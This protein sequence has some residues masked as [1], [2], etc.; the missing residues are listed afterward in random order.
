[1]SFSRVPAR[2]AGLAPVCAVVLGLA[3]LGIGSA[4]GE[5]TGVGF[6]ASIEGRMVVPAQSTQK[7]QD[8]PAE[9]GAPPLPPCA[10]PRKK[11]QLQPRPERDQPS[12]SAPG[13]PEQNLPERFTP[14]GPGAIRPCDQ[15]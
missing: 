2:T 14:C 8:Q 12:R 13:S 15:M 11:R 1:M 7:R 10:R 4:A 9:C 6:P 3:G 5:A